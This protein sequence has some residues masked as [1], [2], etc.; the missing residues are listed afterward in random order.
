MQTIGRDPRRVE[1]DLN[2]HVLRDRDEGAVHLLHEHLARFVER[3]EIGVIAVPLVGQLLH[4]RV[5]QVVVPHPEDAKEN[6][7]LRLLLDHPDEIAFARRPDIEIAV[8]REDDAVDAALDEMLRRGLVGE[9]NA[10]GAVGRA[11]GL[12]I[13]ER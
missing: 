2:L 12:E 8:G 13:F 6:A 7:A 9:L 3:I 1:L 10:L 5:F 11:A 4:H